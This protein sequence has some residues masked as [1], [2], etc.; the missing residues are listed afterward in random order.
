M[1]PSQKKVRTAVQQ[2][3]DVGLRRYL[4][5]IYTYMAL[6]LGL[7]GSI[8]LL[9]GF[10]SPAI[11]SFFAS[12]SWVAMIGTFGIA[13]YFGFGAQRLSTSATQLLFWTY[14]ALMG[15]TLCWIFR[16]YHASSI[17]RVFF[18]TAGTFGA[19]SV[20]GYTTQRD[21]TSVGTFCMMGLFG[22]IIAMI[23]N[24]F[25]RSA[26]FDVALSLIGVI[27]FVGL[28]AYDTQR[29]KELYYQLPHDADLREKISIMGALSLYLDVV[30]LFLSLLRLMGDRK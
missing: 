16:A 10:G 20:Y 12:I 14:S 29:L 8:S 9:I 4:L 19:V 1:A 22:M 28:T 30:N 21:L 15:I 11:Q 18:V 25:F 6:G 27:I 17:A 2:N 26:G 7:T 13:L 5:N 3:V 24:M 23:A